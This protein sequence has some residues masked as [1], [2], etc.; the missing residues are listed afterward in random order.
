MRNDVYTL[1]AYLETITRSKNLIHYVLVKN[2]RR[3]NRYQSTM[4]YEIAAN[5]YTLQ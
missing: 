2:N 3:D 5:K 1:K 4:P